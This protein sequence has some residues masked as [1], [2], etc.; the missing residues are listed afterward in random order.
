MDLGS[1]NGKI[2]RTDEY[3]ELL[4]PVTFHAPVSIHGD[5]F[6]SEKIN[7]VVDLEKLFTQ[8]VTLDTR[9]DL[10]GKVYWIPF[11]KLK[12]DDQRFKNLDYP[13]NRLLTH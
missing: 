12:I 8:S 7:G 9:Q 5:L 4:G 1:I 2:V 13:E 3:A 11:L 6:L 10:A